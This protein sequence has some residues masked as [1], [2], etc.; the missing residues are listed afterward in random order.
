MKN[1]IKIFFV[2]FSLAFLSACGSIFND[3]VNGY[4]STQTEN[5]TV[6]EFQKINFTTTGKVYITQGNIQS[7][8]V[9]AQ[10]NVLDEL[11]TNV[12]GGELRIS[13][14]RCIKSASPIE[15][16]LTM[17]QI[18]GIRL[19]G[20]GD[21]Q[22]MNRWQVNNLDL[23]LSGSGDI[24]AEFDALNAF[25]QLSGSGKIVAS[26]T[27]LDFNTN[28]SGSGKIEAFGLISDDCEARISGS[29]N[30]EVNVSKQLNAQISGSGNIWY[31]GTPNISSQI[32]GSGRVKN[33]N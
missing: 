15:I 26:G 10:R 20:S 31:K 23:Q 12:S 27:S 14:R 22:G 3:C 1:L 29:G 9:K 33:A 30:T 24:R 18:Q 28:L 19:S 4:G 21:V 25:A 5:R 8:V 17:P 16:Y 6:S 2:A 11:N 32:S 13:M 7:V